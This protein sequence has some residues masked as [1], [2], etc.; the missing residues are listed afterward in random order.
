MTAIYKFGGASIKDAN[1][2]KNVVSIILANGSASPIVVVS[3][4]GKMTNALELV[5]H[6]WFYQLAS[7]EERIQFVYQS[8]CSI[9]G[10]LFEDDPSAMDFFESLF[11]QFR[12]SLTIAH[13]PQ[14]DFHYDQIIA[15]GE[16]FSSSIL[17]NYAKKQGLESI[18]VPATDLI[19][20]D[21][22][23]RDA[24]VDWVKTEQAILQIIPNLQ[25]SNS[26]IIT[27][28]FIG[29]APN[30]T[31][32]T[33]GREGSDYTASILS[34]CLNAEQMVIWKD[35]PGVMNADPKYFSDAV[36]LSQLSYREAIEMTY[37]GA[38]VIHPKTIK[39]LQNKKIPLLVRSFIDLTLKGTRI[40]EYDYS[41]QYPPIKVIKQNQ[42]LI[43]IQDNDFAFIAE[44]HLTHIF[45]LIAS[46]RCR[47][48]MMQN[49]AISFSVCMDYNDRIAPLIAAL[50]MNYK[51][52]LNDEVELMTIRH[53]DE[54]AI[55]TFL[56]GRISLLEQRSRSTI[57]MV[58]KN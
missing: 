17:S 54:T 50:Q 46:F 28:G 31:C 38:Q 29:Q 43:S 37:Y 15:W 44:Q 53:Y 30:A 11:Q 26:I 18:L 13:T 34:Y 12:T 56:K 42:V 36:I 39:P 51:V 40:A 4:L 48:N 35:V 27:Q 1:G 8:H 32:T 7:L 47:I 19:K 21:F 9:I 6:D 20:T 2:F 52:V 16:I 58:V 23:Y 25:Q 41:I 55:Q 3:A 49:S 10:E 22:N 33:L 14:Y 57:Q 24:A 5:C 45:Q